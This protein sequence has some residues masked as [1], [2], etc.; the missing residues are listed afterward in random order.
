[1]IGNITVDIVLASYNGEKYISMQIDSILNQSHK[2]FRLYISDDGSTDGTVNI[3]KRYIEKDKR[4][5]LVNTSRVGGVIKNFEVALLYTKA[6][7][8]MLSDQDDY[9]LPDKI[10]QQLKSI[11]KKEEEF[12]DKAILGYTDLELVNE[13]LK[14]ISSSFYNSAKLNPERNLNYCNL[15]WMGS[16]MGC[17]IIMNRMALNNALPFSEN[18]I[19][20]DHWLAMKTLESGHLFY[21]DK[22]YIKYRQHNNNVSGGVGFRKKTIDKVFDLTAYKK[23]INRCKQ[24]SS[25]HELNSFGQRLIFSRN[26][27][28]GFRNCETI[29]YPAL[30][31]L[32]FL[33]LGGK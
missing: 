29:K 9:W 20:H 22:A 3:V 19:M 8:I 17:T 12:K 23:I 7:Y 27:I 1:M 5:Q 33:T 10:E 15:S 25:M 18:I 14:H 4:I 2:N 11:L 26:I 30:F 6:D 32:F 31:L 16:V 28:K 13:D 24:V 21:I